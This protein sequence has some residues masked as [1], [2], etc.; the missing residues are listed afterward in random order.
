MGKELSY[1]I[2]GR[3]RYIAVAFFRR[4]VLG[5][6]IGYCAWVW[7]KKRILPPLAI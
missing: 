6:L 7:V 2:D 4:N 1:M 3:I 5:A